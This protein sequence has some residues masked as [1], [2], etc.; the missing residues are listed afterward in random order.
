MHDEK[1]TSFEG[2]RVFFGRVATHVLDPTPGILPCLSLYLLSGNLPVAVR[3]LPG[4]DAEPWRAPPRSRR[5][6]P[7]IGRGAGGWG[8]GARWALAVLC[9]AR[10]GSAACGKKRKGCHRTPFY[11]SGGV[12]CWGGA[13]G[14]WGAP[15]TN[16]DKA[17]WSRGAPC[18][19]HRAF[20]GAGCGP[21]GPRPTLSGDAS[22]PLY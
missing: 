9:D 10:V 22:M 17:L 11:A 16:H 1:R 18:G 6:C 7:R 4:L 21:R 19:A 13:L 14:R 3:A 5:K 8:P 12:S 2:R 15:T 20:R